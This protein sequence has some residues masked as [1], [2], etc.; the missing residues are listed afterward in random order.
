MTVNQLQFFYCYDLKLFN[1]LNE[2]GFKFITKAKH[3]KTGDI[4][5]MYIKTPKLAEAIDEWSVK[6][7]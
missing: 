1:F 5:S 7:N 4:F 6:S 2:Q 3:Y